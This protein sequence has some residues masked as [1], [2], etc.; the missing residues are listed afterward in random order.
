MFYYA[1]TRMNFT[2]NQ[3]RKYTLAYK[4]WSDNDQS[5]LYQ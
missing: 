3:Q 5:A 4:R 2:D 1:F